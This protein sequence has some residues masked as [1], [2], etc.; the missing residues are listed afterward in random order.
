MRPA[1][2]P[3]GSAASF[4]GPAP[5]VDEELEPGG[6]GESVERRG[7]PC[8]LPGPHSPL[9]VRHEGQVAAIQRADTSH[10]PWGPVGIERVL[11]R[12]VP[13]VIGPVQWSQALGLDLGL[14]FRRR[15][16]HVTWEGRRRGARAELLPA[17]SPPLLPDT[18]RCLPAASPSPWALHT[19]STAPSIPRSIRAGPGP[20]RT[21]AQR[22]S[23]RPD[24]LWRSRRPGRAARDSWPSS[25]SSS[26]GLPPTQPSRASS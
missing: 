9:G 24:R 8:P 14:E 2:S 3:G 17:L 21:L 10:A 22:D 6:G 1:E 18:P 7:L 23:K 26:S 5:G 11:L 4:P 15:K 13:V 20:T 19:G 25:S 12:G 16:G